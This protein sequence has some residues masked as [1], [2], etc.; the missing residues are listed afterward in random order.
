MYENIG[1][2]LY[3]ELEQTMENYGVVREAY[4]G[5]TPNILKAEQAMEEICKFIKDREAGK[6]KGKVMKQKAYKDLVK[7]LSD[8]F[9]IKNFHLEFTDGFVAARHNNQYVELSTMNITG[10]T[11]IPMVTD[12]KNMIKTIAFKSGNTEKIAG[13]KNVCIF[14]Q[15][16]LVT[17]HGLNAEEMMAVLLHEI[18]HSF[19]ANIIMT[20]MLF[21]T[22]IHAPVAFLS[23]S[24][25]NFFNKKLVVTTATFM[26]RLMPEFLSRTFRNIN[27]TTTVYLQAITPPL[28]I[29]KFVKTIQNVLFNPELSAADRKQYLYNIL[30]CGLT[31]YSDERQS[32]SFATAY[33][34]GYALSTGLR[35]LTFVGENTEKAITKGIDT[36]T[37]DILV[38]LGSTLIAFIDPH[39]ATTTRVKNQINKLRRDL[40]KVEDPVM[41]KEIET[42]INQI[43]EFYD[44]Y[45]TKEN[46]TTDMNKYRAM[47]DKILRGD[48]W[49][50][51]L[52]EPYYRAHEL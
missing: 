52:F 45:F 16:T 37:F 19:N 11:N 26:N 50:S 31:G 14:I 10:V 13:A 23:T 27:K 48:D 29:L 51:M 20:M 28:Y 32:D 15:S 3:K 49:Q 4:I 1:M 36:T 44:N 34:Y 5:K 30:T 38:T 33:G 7:Y 43:Q 21:M 17:S 25:N 9:E 39:P 18:G 2:E 12:V 41:K 47:L 6:V 22:F 8:E 46:T 24:I 42:Q 40:A 35:K